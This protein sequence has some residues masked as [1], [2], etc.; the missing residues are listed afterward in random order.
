MISI[1]LSYVESVVILFFT[2]FNHGVHGLSR[3]YT[4]FAQS[5]VWF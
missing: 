5:P 3:S 1:A 4:T 2:F